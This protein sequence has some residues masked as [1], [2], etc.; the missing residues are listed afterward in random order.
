MLLGGKRI[1]AL[2]GHTRQVKYGLQMLA[3]AAKEKQADLVLY[4]HTHMPKVDYIDGIYYLCPGSIRQ[5]S[6]GLADITDSGEIA[7]WTA[8][9]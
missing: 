3:E 9:L 4:G 1:F 8:N 7:C 5:G 6:Y 2:H